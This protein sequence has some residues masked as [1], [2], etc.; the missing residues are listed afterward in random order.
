MIRSG[1]ERIRRTA[2]RRILARA[3]VVGGVAGAAWLLSASSASAADAQ[4]QD[5]SVLSPVTGVLGSATAPVLDAASQLVGGETQTSDQATAVDLPG[6]TAARSTV[7]AGSAEPA[8]SA[9]TDA[10]PADRSS[11]AVVP[12]SNPA[13]RAPL[14][15]PRRAHGTGGD[16]AA[17]AT[18]LDGLVAPL[19]VTRVLT[20][21]ADLLS[22]VARVLD[23]VL[24]PI[25]GALRP[26]TAV[27]RLAA[28]PLTTTL[29]AVTRTA[30]SALPG[31][32]DRSVPDVMPTRH[33]G[34]SRGPATSAAPARA[35]HTGDG[36]H[37]S[38]PPVG[39]RQSAG[40]APSTS[41]VRL[42]A[43][44]LPGRPYP[45]PLRVNLGVGAGVP[46]SGSGSHSEGGA[47][48]TVPSSVAAS[49]ASRRQPI[50]ADAAVLR[51]HAADPTVSPD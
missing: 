37:T 41:T 12:A 32:S 19:G 11:T 14:A 29:D 4:A 33:D 5:A 51:H 1:V 38:R 3:L 23:P 9:S 36:T 31:P 48:A 27:L 8:R 50:T 21:P 2:S 39:N 28:A 24:V 6:S 47:F 35:S 44:D 20:G 30:S 46:A 22:P 45:A 18:T 40:T 42:G 49:Q 34:G 15:Q 16:A 26:V 17:P 13:A 7:V 10:D 25:S 43:G